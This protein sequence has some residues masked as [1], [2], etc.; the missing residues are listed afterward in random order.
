ML[1]LWRQICHED[2][3]V[4]IVNGKIEPLVAV[5]DKKIVHMIEELI[6]N[7]DFK[8]RNLLK[9]INVK[10]I[11]INDNKAFIN[12]NTKEE[13]ENI[14]NITGEFKNLELKRELPKK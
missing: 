8:I 5:Y 7:N 13:Y 11:E 14:K 9:L 10:Y 3:L 1:W 6:D 4:P 12:V 2:A